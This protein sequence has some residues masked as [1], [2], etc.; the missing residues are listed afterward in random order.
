ML[1]R[2]HFKQGILKSMNGLLDHLLKIGL[3]HLPLELNIS[4]QCGHG[5]LKKCPQQ[6]SAKKYN[7]EGASDGP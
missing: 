6:L 1:A 2:P 3:I 7:G 5:I 4:Q